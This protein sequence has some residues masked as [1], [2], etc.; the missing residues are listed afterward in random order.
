M[1]GFAFGLRDH[2][3]RMVAAD[4][5]ES[6]QDLIASTDNHERL[7]RQIPRDVLTGLANLFNASNKLP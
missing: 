1:G 5:E 7:T 3:S 4:V 6:A 2:G